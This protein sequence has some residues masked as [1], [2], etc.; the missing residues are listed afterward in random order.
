NG[1]SAARADWLPDLL[2]CSVKLL[3]VDGDKLLDGE[4]HAGSQDFIALNQPYLPAGDPAELMLMVTS[5][6]NIVTA[7]FRLI[8]GLGLKH[9]LRVMLWTLAW[10]PHRLLLRSVAIEDFFSAVPITIGPQ[11]VKFKWQSQQPAAVD[12]TSGASRSN[13][14]RDDL[15]HRL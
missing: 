6:A 15:R 14:L 3:G 13:Y 2:G 5:A 10:T 11:A 12:N 9:A 7:P 1:F 4:E 8:R